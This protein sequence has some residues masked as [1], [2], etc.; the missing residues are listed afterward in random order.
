[1]NGQEQHRLTVEEYVGIQTTLTRLETVLSG[2]QKTDEEIQATLKNVKAGLGELKNGV[3]A[4]PCKSQE[5][6]L[7]AV[8]KRDPVLWVKIFG[9]VIAM[10]VAIFG[11]I[12]AFGKGGTP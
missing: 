2:M 3:Q 5:S 7:R 6:R 4:L 9:L 10:L 8:E 12:E 11:L 1:M